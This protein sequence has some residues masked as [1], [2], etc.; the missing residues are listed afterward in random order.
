MKDREV[1]RPNLELLPRN[2]HGKAGNKER[3]RRYC[4]SK[5]AERGILKFGDNMGADKGL[6]RTEFRRA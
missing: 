4:S 5:T 1:W 3:R 2:H 6:F